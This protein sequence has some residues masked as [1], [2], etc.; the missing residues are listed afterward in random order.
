VILVDWT[1]GG[2]WISTF[3]KKPPEVII[4]NGEGKLRFELNLIKERDSKTDNNI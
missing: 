4:I 3:D 2:K 1:I